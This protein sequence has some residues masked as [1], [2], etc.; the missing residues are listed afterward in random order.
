M[1]GGIP[2]DVHK[3]VAGSCLSLV[4]EHIFLSIGSQ[5]LGAVR[6]RYPSRNGCPFHLGK[7]S[8]SAGRKFYRIT[9]PHATLS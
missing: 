9:Y 6:D 2:R 3:I 1:A 5:T 7:E 4:R 8:P